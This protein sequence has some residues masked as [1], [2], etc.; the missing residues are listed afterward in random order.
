MSNRLKLMSDYH[1]WSLWEM[2]EGC[3]QNINP[4][5]LPL[6]DDLKSS[7]HRWAV[8]FDRTLNHDY[9]PESG[10]ARPEAEEAFESEGLRIWQELQTQLCE[11]YEVVYYSQHLARVLDKLPTKSEIHSV[12]TPS[13]VSVSVGANTP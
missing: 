12:P 9:P 1:C 6:S 13:S 7:L 11:A 4:E 8:S 3:Y 2:H 10:F 5:E